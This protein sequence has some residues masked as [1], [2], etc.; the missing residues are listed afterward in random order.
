MHRRDDPSLSCLDFLLAK[1]SVYDN[2]GPF[3]TYHQQQKQHHA[4]HHP[5]AHSRATLTEYRRIAICI[6]G[7][8]RRR[9]F[10]WG[11]SSM[12]S[13]G[14]SWETRRTHIIIED[15]LRR[16]PPR[17]WVRKSFYLIGRRPIWAT[18]PTQI[19]PLVVKRFICSKG[20]GPKVTFVDCVGTGARRTRIP[21][22]G[23]EFG[24]CALENNHN[25]WWRLKYVLNKLLQIFLSNP[26]LLWWDRLS[27]LSS[28]EW[29]GSFTGAWMEHWP[30]CGKLIYGHL[31]SNYSLRTFQWTLRL[32]PSSRPWIPRIRLIWFRNSLQNAMSCETKFD[33][34][35]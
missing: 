17:R 16:P 29:K 9:P 1:Y 12:L 4:P 18:I 19:E 26:L 6:E 3:I 31:T 28:Q 15:E 22:W 27:W 32:A 20:S 25:I 2:V 30:H 13:G 23:W 21:R 7:C 14:R 5:S 35:N 11:H 33:T 34:I 24:H 10:K 8:R